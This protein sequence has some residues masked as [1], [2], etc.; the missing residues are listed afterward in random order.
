MNRLLTTLAARAR[1]HASGSHHGRGYVFLVVALAVFLLG[2][3]CYRQPVTGY[4]ARAVLV[5]QS[6]EGPKSLSPDELQSRLAAEI[7]APQAMS[8]LAKSTGFV[9][10]PSN[11]EALRQRTKIQIAREPQGGATRIV[12]WHAGVDADQSVVIAQRLAETYTLAHSQQAA[13]RARCAQ[14]DT[15]QA[16][17]HQAAAAKESAKAALDSFREQ[18]AG[19]L[20]PTPAAKPAAENVKEPTPANVIAQAEVPNPAWQSLKNQL[21]VRQ[22]ALAELLRKRTP[23]HP[24]VL[25]MVAQVEQVRG[26]LS[27]TPRM[28]ATTKVPDA[29]PPAEPLPKPEV[30]PQIVLQVSK[31][32]AAY[33]VATRRHDEALAA[34]RAAWQNRWSHP[35][36]HIAIVEPAH[37]IARHGGG[38]SKP[39][40][41]LV[42]LIAIVAGGA[43]AWR[44]QLV[45]QPAAL[46]SAAQVEQLGLPV[47]AV[48]AT[49]DGPAIP[50]PQISNPSWVR[51]ITTACEMSLAVILALLVVVVLADWQ[52]A[53]Q[54][55]W[56]PLNAFSEAVWRLT[57]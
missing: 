55:I 16:A 35:A 2:M 47:V 45:A 34:E 33:D 31:L 18:H 7:L 43:C 56:D 32:K 11:C 37:I 49:R 8:A 19:E 6:P 41:L 30:D 27:T 13:S 46:T 1:W 23:E 39:G 50:Q 17:V 21:E 9:N 42:G 36:E 57:P 54:A 10:T 4:T 24:E 53:A 51:H 28:L 52:V 14:C 20:D 15:A 44:S 22:T 29:A 40:V 26:Q 12:L 48:L 5:Q 38:P 25:D 3:V